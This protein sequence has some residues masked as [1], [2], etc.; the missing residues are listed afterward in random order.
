MVLDGKL[1]I[2]GGMTPNGLTLAADVLSVKDQS[3]SQ[4]QNT[5]RN[6][7]KRR[8]WQKSVLTKMQSLAYEIIRVHLRINAMF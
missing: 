1:Y 4:T 3:A 6:S 2:M 7:G 8:W 5:K